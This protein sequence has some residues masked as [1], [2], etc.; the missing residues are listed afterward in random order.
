MVL[1]HEK[2]GAVTAA[3]EP[4]EPAGHVNSLLEAI[5]PA[6]FMARHQNSKDLLDK[7]IRNNA[8]MV[9]EQINDSLPVINDAVKNKGVVVV[10]AY[11]H[12]GTGRVEIL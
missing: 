10:S 9:G 7:S 3:L 4:S 1:G 8:L 12:L 6:V 5:R 11:Y 2:C